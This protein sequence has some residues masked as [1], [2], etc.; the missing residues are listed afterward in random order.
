[1][2]GRLDAADAA[3]TRKL[4]RTVHS[5]AR[6]RTRPVVDRSFDLYR[7][8][9]NVSSKPCFTRDDGECAVVLHRPGDATSVGSSM[10]PLW[11]DEGRRGHPRQPLCR[12]MPRG[13]VSRLLHLTAPHG[14]NVRLPVQEGLIASA[15]DHT[16][17]FKNPT[18]LEPTVGGEDVV[19][20]DEEHRTGEVVAGAHL[21]VPGRGAMADHSTPP[22]PRT[23]QHR[24]QKRRQLD[25]RRNAEHHTSGADVLRRPLC[26]VVTQG[27]GQTE[28][29]AHEQ[30]VPKQREDEVHRFFLVPHTRL[31]KGGL[32]PTRL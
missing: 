24:R 7:W 8:H 23:I 13:T 4:S 3:A 31:K 15:L 21:A 26:V 25:A 18:A 1:M 29:V 22:T 27:A 6:E 12:P 14:I 10:H 11:N 5:L 28:H 2:D 30:V 17:P 9:S 16:H 32:T 19:A 20:I